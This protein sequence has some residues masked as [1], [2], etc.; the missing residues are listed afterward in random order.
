MGYFKKV[1]SKIEMG[2]DSIKYM[3]KMNAPDRVSTEMVVH[4]VESNLRKLM[5][6]V[7]TGVYAP[8]TKFASAVT[9]EGK[10]I[11]ADRTLNT[12]QESIVRGFNKKQHL[13]K[14]SLPRDKVLEEIA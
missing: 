1:D 14:K 13:R 12:V 7:K 3:E 8:V 9:S 5:R 11:R 2:K 4:E 6:M 10:S